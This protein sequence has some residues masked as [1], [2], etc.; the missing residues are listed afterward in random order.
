MFGVH[1]FLRDILGITSLVC[2]IVGLKTD[3][4]LNTVGIR[5]IHTYTYENN[6]SNTEIRRCTKHSSFL[7]LYIFI[8]VTRILLPI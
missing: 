5:Y 1:D 8:L 6:E 2:M 3:L 7:P 4:I